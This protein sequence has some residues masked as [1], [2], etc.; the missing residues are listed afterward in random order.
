MHRLS[1]HAA[2][3]GLTGLVAEQVMP[4]AV[5]D[6]RNHPRFKYFKES[7]EEVYH[8]F[9]GVPAD[10]P[11]HSAGRARGANQRAQSLPRK[12]N[13]QVVRGRQPGRTR[14]QRGA[15]PRSLYRP[16]PGAPLVRRPQ[17]LVVLG[18]RLHQPVSR[19]QSHPLVAA[20]SESHRP[21]QRN[22]AGGNRA[23]RHRTGPAQPHQLCLPPPAGISARPTA[24]GA[25]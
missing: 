16:G 6:A 18:L 5:E 15:H 11:R 8:S 23:P 1:A 13:S 25:P 7:G 21:A 22:A 4:V 19:P 2:H 17:S 12:R 24:P 3:E 9:L 10:R 20:Q 14:G